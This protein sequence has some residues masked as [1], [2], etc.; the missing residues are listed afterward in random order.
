MKKFYS[1]LL[2]FF[3]FLQSIFP[4]S[5]DSTGFE[6]VYLPTGSVTEHLPLKPHWNLMLGTGL[7]ISPHYGNSGFFYAAPS[8]TIPVNNRFTIHT[9]LIATT[10]YSPIP[11]PSNEFPM[12]NTFNSLSLYGS[13]S[14]LLN[15]NLEIYTVGTKRLKEMPLMNSAFL[16]YSPNSFTIGS[17]LKIGNNISIGASFTTT[18]RY[19]PFY[20]SS[21]FHSFGRNSFFP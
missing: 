18:D 8:F 15:E 17:T 10:T 5:P 9:G 20:P 2:C 21:P 7:S 16:P 3:F 4:Q 19:Q 11:G 14:Y 6:S 13:A 1:V 12:R